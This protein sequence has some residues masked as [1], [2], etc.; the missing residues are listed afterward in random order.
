M[1]SKTGRT[2]TSTLHLFG[3]PNRATR[4]KSWT[5][6]RHRKKLAGLKFISCGH[7]TQTN[8]IE[9]HTVPDEHLLGFIYDLA[10][11]IIDVFERKADLDIFAFQIASR[12]SFQPLITS[13]P[14]ITTVSSR[15]ASMT[16][17]A[18]FVPDIAA[19]I[20]TASR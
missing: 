15:A 19:P 10:R 14:L 12:S 6:W 18:F 3:S 20:T 17:G 5:F 9:Q 11:Q 16:M 1:L 4:G 8:G 13:E 7:A 2:A